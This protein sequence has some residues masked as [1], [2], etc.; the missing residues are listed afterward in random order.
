MSNLFILGVFF[1]AAYGWVMNI[2]ILA[3]EASMSTGM[4]LVRAA[5]IFVV[6]LGAILGFV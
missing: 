6:P 3:G 2:V 4:L 5:G 1:L